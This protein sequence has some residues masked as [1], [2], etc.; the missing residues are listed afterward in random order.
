MKINTAKRHLREGTKNIIRNGW[1]TIAAVGAVT[2]TLILVAAFLMLILNLNQIADNIE[3]DVEIRVYIDLNTSEDEIDELGEQIASIDQVSDHYFSSKD[4]ELEM[5]IEDL[6]EEGEAYELFEQDNPLNHVYVIST[7]QA[8]DLS[9]VANRIDRMDHVDEVNYRSDVVDRLLEFNKYAR[10][11]GIIFITALLL[12]A[13]FLISNTIR[14]TITARKDEIGIMRLV[15][16]KNSFIRWPFFVEGMLTGVLG[17]FLPVVLVLG[18]YHFLYNSLSEQ[19]N[20]SFV[21]LLPWNPFAWQLSLILLGIGALI[22]IWGSVMS[23]RKFL[24]I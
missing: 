7:E 23:V 1:M 20:F 21:E 5:L 13:S 24:K 3:S 6:G 12:T 8:E 15:G 19:I 14:M 18:G 11:I 10:Y 2:T 22:G 16:A 17:A 4:E 9:G